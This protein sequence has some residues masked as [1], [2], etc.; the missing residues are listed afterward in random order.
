[1]GGLGDLIFFL[2]L[3]LFGTYAF[4]GY[5]VTILYY[6]VYSRRFFGCSSYFLLIRFHC[7]QPLA[8]V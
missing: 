7:I 8:N 3:F 2:L 4:D 5:A 1:V 6:F